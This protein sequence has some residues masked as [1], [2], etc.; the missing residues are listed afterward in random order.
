MGSG[1]D[2]GTLLGSQGR[3]GGSELLLGDLGLIWERF[4]GSR[5]WFGAVFGDGF[6]IFWGLLGGLWVILGCIF[7]A[8]W[9]DFRTILGCIFRAILGVVL[10]SF[11]GDFSAF[12]KQLWVYFRA[13]WGSFCGVS[14]GFFGGQFQ[15]H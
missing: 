13:V 15:G 14:S 11:W 8:I 2:L 10:G 12:L 7:R 9:G 3:L 5:G 4:E 6:R 1:G